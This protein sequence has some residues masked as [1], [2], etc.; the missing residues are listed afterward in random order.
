[1]K[2]NPFG[3]REFLGT[4]LR[5]AA[6]LA[7]QQLAW[8]SLGAVDVLMIGQ[9]GETALAGVAL[10]NQVFFLLSLLVFGIGTG[11]AVFG[12]QFWGRRD[13][14]HVR[15]ILGLALVL[16]L[17][18]SSIFTCL[19]VFAPHYVLGIYSQ[20]PQV[21]SVGGDYLRIVGLSYVVTTITLTYSYVLRST[22]DVKTPMLVSLVALVLKTGLG[23]LLIFGHLGLP[24]MGTDGAAIAT[25]VARYAECG[26]LLVVVYGRRLPVA[27]RLRELFGWSRAL[28]KGFVITALPVIV[29][30]MGWAFGV[31]TYNAI[32]AHIGTDAIAAVNIAATIEGIIFV[33]LASLANACA[34]MVGNQI[35]AGQEEKAS[36]YAYRYLVIG[37]VTAV[38]LGISVML[39]SAW[40]LSFYN[41]TAGTFS[42]A[43]YTLIV[44]G[45]LF[46]TKGVNMMT[47]VG[48]LRGGGDTRYA[49]AAEMIS[50]WLV[51][52]PLALFGAFV[53]HLP[54]QW[55]VLMALC[56]EVIKVFIT[57]AR[58]LSGRWVH[59]VVAHI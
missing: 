39:A 41:I 33:F 6:P 11:A 22:G 1:M 28:V 15:K 5:L 30:E 29:S 21:I 57:V 36:E 52:V 55:V 20:D 32:Y 10:A 25:A 50:V 19:A 14:P 26:V 49:L 35:G 58:V 53:L 24:T 44:L 27:A 56:E 9:L 59:N 8:A 42:S 40:I 23:Y 4:M 17:A 51:G 43:R 34:V 7:L 38:V 12:A 46:W 37:P 31:T 16:G 48:I 2:L 3:D 54:V 13:L 47:I 18:G 45:A